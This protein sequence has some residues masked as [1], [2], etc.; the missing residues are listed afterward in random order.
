MIMIASLAN[1][2]A[3]QEVRRFDLAM[4]GGELAPHWRTLRVKQGDVVE[5][6]WTS[7]RPV[8]LHLHGYDIELRVKPGEPAVMAFKAAEAGRFG[9]TTV[10]EDSGNA[11][12][13]QHGGRVMYL[14]VYP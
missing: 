3:A 1:V 10:R 13:H 8:H 7:E 6:H 4:K 9:V 14:E 11:R 2:V 5:M 12:S